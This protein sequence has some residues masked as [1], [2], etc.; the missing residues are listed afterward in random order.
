MRPGGTKCRPRRRHKRD[1]RTQRSQG[2]TVMVD[3]SPLGTAT[4]LTRAPRAL[5]ADESRARLSRLIA[6]VMSNVSR[7][8]KWSLLRDGFE[9]ADD[10]V[11]DAVLVEDFEDP[12]RAQRRRSHRWFPR[13]LVSAL[14]QPGRSDARPRAGDRVVRVRSACGSPPTARAPRRAY[15][16]V[17]GGCADRNPRHA[18]VA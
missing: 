17:R 14:R 9:G 13:T 7:R 10:D 4:V 8:R 6:G 1:S 18:R 15:R 2:A 11:V 16:G 3:R 12:C 5:S